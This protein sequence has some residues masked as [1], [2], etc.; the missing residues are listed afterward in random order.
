[1]E[2]DRLEEFANL[3]SLFFERVTPKGRRVMDLKK[4]VKS[5]ALED[6]GL[7]VTVGKDGGRPKPAELLQGIFHLDRAAALGARALKISAEMMEE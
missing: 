2:Q 4:T 3:E 1:M 5:I 6:N 7:S